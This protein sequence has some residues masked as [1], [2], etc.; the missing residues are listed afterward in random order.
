MSGL[1]PWIACGAAMAIGV[2]IVI[3]VLAFA[4]AA[5]T[6]LVLMFVAVILGAALEPVVGWLRDK[7]PVARGA[8]ILLVYGTFL[9]TT[10]L[11]FVIVPIAIEQWG[12]IMA[13][14]P[15]FLDSAREW[16]SNLQSPALSR[17]I[18]SVIRPW[19]TPCRRPM[20]RRRARRSS[21]SA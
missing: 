3:G 13:A 20:P 4:W 7:L 6:V 11:A 16:A 15:A 14:L 5:G 19:A 9:A 21:R 12:D 8:A 1:A 17:A 10:A 2:A 18:T